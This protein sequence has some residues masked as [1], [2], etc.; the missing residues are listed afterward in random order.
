MEVI[1]NNLD[2]IRINRGLSVSELSRLSGYSRK[3]IAKLLSR[4]TDFEIRLAITVRLAEILNVDFKKLFK[5]GEAD[6]GSFDTKYT[7]DRYLENFVKN[8]NNVLRDKYRYFIKVESGLSQS[9]ISDLLNGKTRNPQ[10]GTLIKIA[11]S[12]KVPIE[13]LFE[14]VS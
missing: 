12:I 2:K 10:V 4:T 7:A 3:S 14:E 9:T 8:V 5:R 11:N 1:F 13:K 6:Y